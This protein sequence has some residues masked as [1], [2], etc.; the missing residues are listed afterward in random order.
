MIHTLIT[1]SELYKTWFLCIFSAEMLPLSQKKV[2]ENGAKVHEKFWNFLLPDC[3]E[4]WSSFDMG[5][6]MT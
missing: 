1:S 5:S 2:L 3:W 4:P 6:N